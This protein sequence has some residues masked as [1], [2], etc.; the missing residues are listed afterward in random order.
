MLAFKIRTEKFILD[1]HGGINKAFELLKYILLMLSRWKST[2]QKH[3]LTGESD[4]LTRQSYLV[5]R[6]SAESPAS[7][8]VSRASRSE[9]EEEEEGAW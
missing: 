4:S 2:L 1:P 5:G 6:H 9:E 8:S 3:I 7:A